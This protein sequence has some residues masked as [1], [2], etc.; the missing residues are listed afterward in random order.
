MPAT[1]L[2]LPLASMLIALSAMLPYISSAASWADPAKV[3]RVALDS[4]INGLDPAATDDGVS[5]AVE[6]GGFD[7]L[8]RWDY[9][10]STSASNGESTK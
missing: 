3:L 2:S 1:T 5:Y 7:S 6:V 10:E 4:D 9:L 8:Y